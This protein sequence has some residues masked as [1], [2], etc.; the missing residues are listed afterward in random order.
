MKKCTILFL[1]LLFALT[2]V[3][4]EDTIFIRETRIPILIER[5]D[6][7]LFYLRLNAKESRTLNDVVL[8]FG[9]DVN[10]SEIE[11][12]KLYYSGTEALQDVPKKRFAPVNY[13]SSHTPGK[14]LAAN[15]SYS[16][17]KANATNLK[18]EVQLKGNQKLF[19][20]INFFWISLQMKPTAPLNTKVV[21]DITSITLDGKAALLDVVSTEGIEH[22]MGVGVRHAGDDNS[23]AFRIPGLATTNKGT[24]LSVYDVRYNSA[25]D[26]QEHVDVGLSR[27]TDGGQTW[28]KMRLPLV[29]GEYDGM[30]A[31]Q[32]GVGDPSILVDT[33][34]NTA[35]IVAAWT[36][37]MGNQRAWW[38]SHQGMDLNHTAQLVL[39]KSEDDGKTWSAPINITEQV[40]DPSWY[41]L[42]QGPGRGIT[43]SDGTLVF[44]TQFIDST[45]VPNAGIMY[46]KDRGKTWK[47]HN[48]ARTN[49]TEAQV[50]EVEPGVLM[51]NMRDNRGGSRA[52]STTKDLG[53]TWTEHVS[54]RKALQESVCMASLLSVKA[55]ENILNK[56]I[57]LFSNP[58]TTKGRHSTTIKVSLDGGVTWL[59][60]Y[61]LLLDEDGNWG[62]SCLTMI[63][64][65][66]I[67][68]LYESSVAHMTFQAIKLKDIVK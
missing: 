68:I 52:V 23:A 4:A 36:H 50:A 16:I 8:K 3:K 19:P 62:Y 60:E 25:V 34:T 5:Q 55:K 38:S 37:G 31:G 35:W 26:L 61:Q 66:T 39:A 32:N 46:S 1:L 44:P 57:L 24:L 13:I 6:N 20:G 40:K 12:V 11:S 14:T 51:L 47:M 42:L 15:L 41:F 21:A 28:E 56:D 45:R 30:P 53:K 33:K 10:L 22:R 48:Y 43:M 59:P 18:Q 67:G 29:F 64:K 7:V 27:S 54:S 17:M 63:D 2:G 49:T 65:E 9:N 58:N